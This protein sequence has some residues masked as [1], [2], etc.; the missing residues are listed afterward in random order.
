MTLGFCSISALDRPLAEAA[1]VAAEAGVDGLEISEHA[2]HLAPG[3]DVAAAA[4]AGRVVRAAG[5]EVLAFGSYLGRED[6]SRK[7]AS[8]AVERA[9]AMGAPLLRVW[10]EPAATDGDR[11][12]LVALL[13]QTCDA[14]LAHEID[15]V[16]ERH[17]GSWADTPDRIA[18]LLRDVGRSNFAL[19]YQPLDDLPLSEVEDQRDDARQL[20]GLA[21]YFHLKNYRRGQEGEPLLPGAALGDG[22]LDYASI[23]E[24]AFAAGFAGPLTIEFLSWANEPLE[25]KLARD[26][27]YVRGLLDRLAPS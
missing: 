19:N 17:R 20:A 8:S 5:L 11:A 14:A 9:A 21:R 12:A 6:V 24:S 26:V 3:D 25:I 2:P 1:R 10:A 22:A 27:A 15:V 16:V 18:A 13:A 7:A 23:L 4:E